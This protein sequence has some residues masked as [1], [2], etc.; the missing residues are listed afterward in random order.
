MSFETLLIIFDLETTGFSGLPFMSSMNRIIQIS[1]RPVFETRYREMTCFVNPGM[2]EIPPLATNLNKIKLSDVLYAKPFLEVFND[3][4]RHFEMHRWKSVVM[5]SHNGDHFDE[6]VLRRHLNN[7]LPNNMKFFDTLPFLRRNYPELGEYNLSFLYK[8]LYGTELVGSHRADADVGALLSIY[9]DYVHEKALAQG[10][11]KERDDALTSLKFIGDYRAHRIQQVLGTKTLSDF[12]KY[13]HDQ[14]PGS[15]NAFL[16][17]VLD[18]D[19]IAARQSI[20]LDMYGYDRVMTE[21]RPPCYLN[22]AVNE[23]EFF[24]RCKYLTGC[25]NEMIGNVL[26]I[27]GLCVMNRPF[28]K[29]QY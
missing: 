29:Y 4:Y 19:D 7:E 23:V 15:L 6:P 25:A 22:G 2:V 13:F 26:Y 16:T 21:V 9:K 12:I 28:I 27:R 18:I 17:D 1:C 10:F 3:V 14:K 8:T 20:V 24:A 11:V 5:I